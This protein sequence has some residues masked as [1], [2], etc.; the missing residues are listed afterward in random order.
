MSKVFWLVFEV[1]LPVMYRNRRMLGLL[2]FTRCLGPA[3]SSRV[4][5]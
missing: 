1:K 3:S 5:M 4:S 2:C